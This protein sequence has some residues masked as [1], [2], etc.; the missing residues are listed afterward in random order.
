MRMRSSRLC[1]SLVLTLLT[2]VSASVHAQGV[3]NAVRN[4]LIFGKLATPQLNG[5]EFRLLIA[6]VGEADVEFEVHTYDFVGIETAFSAGSNCGGLINDVGATRGT[7]PSH[8]ACEA[9][10]LNS[11]ERPDSFHAEILI[12]NG[13]QA[14]LRAVMVV[15][16]NL[17]VE[18]R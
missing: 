9:L 2:G 7:L 12:L 1:V 5:H 3:G 18:G 13:D 14:N 6:N 16:Q 15:D 4:L 10:N 11:E 17:V 8:H